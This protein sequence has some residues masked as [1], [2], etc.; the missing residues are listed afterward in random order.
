MS[1][2]SI[3]GLPDWRQPSE[4]PAK[5]TD[6]EWR[7]EFLRRRPG[8]RAEWTKWQELGSPDEA[9]D[10]GEVM[11]AITDD[12]DS[13]RLA[14]GVSVI[15]DPRKSM[16][17]DLLFR[18]SVFFPVGCIVRDLNAVHVLDAEVDEINGEPISECIRAAERKFTRRLAAEEDAG[19]VKY[20]FDVSHSLEP[21]LERA[22]KHLR[23]IQVERHGKALIA[24]PRRSSWPLFLRALDAREC[25]ASWSEMAKTFWSGCT[26]TYRDAR[27]IHSFAVQVR[28]YF[29]V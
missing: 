29:P 14:F 5:A 19:L 27:E 10:D 23:A 21:Q 6:R 20:R 9:S 11:Y 25:G 24:R 8:Y 18:A 4:Y 2:Q 1:A 3:W 17:D 7:W 12:P 13:M 26:K 28:D 16:P 22:R 15:Y